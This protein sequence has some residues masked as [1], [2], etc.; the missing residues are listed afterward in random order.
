MDSGTEIVNQLWVSKYPSES[1]VLWRW[2]EYYFG[3]YIFESAGHPGVPLEDWHWTRHSA[4]QYQGWEVHGKSCAVLITPLTHIT[5]SQK[6]WTKVTQRK[7]GSCFQQRMVSSRRQSNQK[8]FK[9][10]WTVASTISL[11]WTYSKMA[12]RPTQ[13]ISGSKLFSNRAMIWAWTR[14]RNELRMIDTIFVASLIMCVLCHQ[15]TSLLM[16]RFSVLQSSQPLARKFQGGRRKI[17]RWQ[18]LPWNQV[19]KRHG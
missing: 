12:C 17:H 11:A 15:L 1:E 9:S 5:Q 7:P 10:C 18:L 14:S 2:G 6:T 19:N 4:D 13:K 8:T 3:T 16:S